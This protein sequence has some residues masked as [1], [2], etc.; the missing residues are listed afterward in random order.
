MFPLIPDQL[1]RNLGDKIMDCEG[2]IPVAMIRGDDGI[3]LGIKDHL[4][5]MSDG[6]KTS[7]QPFWCLPDTQSTYIYCCLMRWIWSAKDFYPC[8]LDNDGDSADN[9]GEAEA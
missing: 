9:W 1:I 2:S 8:L 3:L 5:Y 4:I 6:R 7:T